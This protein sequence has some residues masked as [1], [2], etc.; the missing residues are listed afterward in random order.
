MDYKKKYLKYKSKY[1]NLSK[2][3]Q[4]GSGD[5]I[6]IKLEDKQDIENFLYYLAIDKI[7]YEFIYQITP[8][9][10]KTLNTIIRENKVKSITFNIFVDPKNIYVIL[11]NDGEKKQMISNEEVFFN[12]NFL[13]LL[14]S[15]KNNTILYNRLESSDITK[16]KNINN[17]IKPTG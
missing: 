7:D 8:R 12:T 16:D 10:K 4:S 17:L 14:V 11:I 2:I 1:T 6:Q 5:N 3:K 15:D 9:V 13:K